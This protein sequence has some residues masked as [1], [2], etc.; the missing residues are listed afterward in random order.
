[1]ANYVGA[2]AAATTSL[3][4]VRV[5]SAEQLASWGWRLPFFASVLLALVGLY[6]RLRIPDSPAFQDVDPA[7]HSAGC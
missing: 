7:G 6:L 3:V 5:L 2:A 1:V 4:L